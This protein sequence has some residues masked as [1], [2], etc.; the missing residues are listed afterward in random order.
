ML[1]EG[2][3]LFA[4]EQ[5][6]TGASGAVAVDLQAGGQLTLGRG[7]SLDLTS[8]LLNHQPGHVI[9][10]DE[11]TP[12]LAEPGQTLLP[13]QVITADSQLQ[14][15]QTPPAQNAA[16]DGSALGGGHSAL[17]VTEVGGEVTPEIGFATQ[18]FTVIPEYP[19]GRI[20]GDDDSAETSRPGYQPPAS[21]EPQ[22]TPEAPEE[23]PTTPPV[24]PESPVEPPVQPPVEPP[25]EPPIE[26]EPPVEP[27]VEPRDHDVQLSDG[28]LTLN[29]ADLPGGPVTQTGT[30]TVNAADGLQSL[31]VGGLAVV[32]AG[33]VAGFPLSV[34][35]EL[36]NTFSVTGYDPA[37]GE[38]SYSYTLQSA[39]E[40]PSG[41]GT[42]SAGE[43][44]NVIAHDADGDVANSHLDINIIDDVPVAQCIE[45]TLTADPDCPGAPLPGVSGSLLQ[46]G[47]FGADGGFVHAISIDGVT[48]SFD[49]QTGL[50]SSSCDGGGVFDP[51]TGSLTV[52]S[53][54]GGTLVVNMLNGDFN[55]TPSADPG[56]EPLTENIHYVISDNDGDLAAA[57]LL[58]NV[59]AVTP[60]E[61]PTAVADNIITNV[62]AP[63]IQVPGALLLA[64][65][66]PGS[67]GPLTATP[68]GFHTGWQAKGDGFSNDCLKTIDFSGK[69][70]NDTNQL[71]NLE[72]SDFSN[73]GAMTAM[74]VI[75]GYLG[76]WSGPGANAQDLYSVS[77]VAGERVTVDL[78]TL[79][80]GVGVLWQLDGGQYQQL[81]PGGCFTANETGV[82]RILLVNQPDPGHAD[83]AAH[84]SLNLAVD[85]SAA[86]TTP[87]YEGTYTVHDGHGGSDSAAVNITYQESCVLLGTTGNDVL[88]G[89]DQDDSLHGGEGDDVLSGGA[90]NNDLYGD[91]GNDVLFSGAGNDVL[92]G[93]SGNNTASYALA[94]S[95]VVVSTAELGPQHTGGAGTDTLIDIQNLIGSNFNDRLTGD[96]ENN[97]INGG[98]GH[99]VLIG[100]LGNDTLTGG[101]GSDT[102]KWLAG[103][104][105]HDKVTDFSFGSDTLDLSQLL[106][107]AGAGADSLDDFLHF[108]VTGSG[109]DLVSTIEV[110]PAHQSSQTIDLAGVD[111]AHHYGVGVG[112]G[113]IVSGADAGSIISGMLNDHSMRA[114][115]A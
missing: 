29:E 47:T 15:P 91:S 38:V 71:K 33:V 83:A 50:C 114:D 103:D 59:P 112:A 73:T 82:Y 90:G 93:G 4:G 30:F 113:G 75:A 86:D 36:G 43:S 68:T 96:Y 46:G 94:E 106:Q 98:L 54:A 10:G 39:I 28:A 40:H 99:D 104:S 23:S 12:T 84:Y 31:I 49:P 17:L 58:I 89:G 27:P 53:A 56:C 111:L 70:N 24:E 79:G 11:L 18:G 61:A 55:Y 14:T 92:D 85:Y 37:T 107:G 60:P 95:G 67:G 57:D 77:L 62:L 13:D 87:G 21:V 88:L 63:C 48:Y 8:Q 34:T 1:I 105:G 22:P 108:K 81:E 45:V 74:V 97:V 101:A 64:N 19:E 44:F 66:L 7:S 35:T 5:L 6:Q 76:A 2:D 20:E 25:V 52:S 72:R 16:P 100:G 9:T 32:T 69:R 109:A 51:A 102:F 78:N 26:P 80:D 41:N 110:G 115:V 65:D 3:R 42:N